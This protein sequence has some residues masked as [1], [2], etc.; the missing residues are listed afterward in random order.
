LSNSKKKKKI[1]AR[2]LID[3][4]SNAMTAKIKITFENFYFFFF[5]NKKI[6]W[7]LVLKI[8]NMAFRKSRHKERDIRGR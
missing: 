6:D 7:S 4:C 3:M 8:L 5:S 2:F 1:S